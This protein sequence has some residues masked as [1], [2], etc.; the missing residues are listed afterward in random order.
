[1]C[2]KRYGLLVVN[3]VIAL[4]FLQGCQKSPEDDIVTNKNEGVLESI[5]NQT[6]NDSASQNKESIPETY[7]D[8][9]SNDSGDL[10]FNVEADI[11]VAEGDLPV[12]RVA[13]HEI[14]SEE[15]QHWA[16]VLFE[17]KTAYEPTTVLSKSEIEEKILLFRQKAADKDAL[18]SEYGSESEAQAM[19][20]YYNSEAEAYEQLY[21]SAPET[22]ERTESDWTFH[23]Y[24]YYFSN[25]S[26]WD[27]SELEK[28]KQTSELK[29][30]AFDVNG[31]SPLIDALN[32]SAD[33]FKM[34]SLWFWY[35]DEELLSD[36][37]YKEITAEEAKS[38]ADDIIKE[39][40]LENWSI[41]SYI[42][43]SDEAGSF[44]TFNYVP[45]FSSVETIPGLN[46]D[47][48]SDDLYAAN[49]EYSQLEVSVYNG[50]I[51]TVLLT[52][53]LD[54]VEVVNSNVSTLSFDEIYSK[55]KT[56][57]QTQYSLNSFIVGFD[58]IPEYKNAKVDLT[59]TGIQL[60]LV[61]IKEK[62]NDDEYLMVPAWLFTGD[63]HMNDGDGTPTTLC[64][65]NA[66]DGSVINPTLGY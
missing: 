57:M 14:T 36:I 39:L 19:I 3:I 44:Y 30:A 21:E 42:D 20:D 11:Q 33:D 59:V 1:M 65:I 53:P 50:I 63:V 23:S 41:W 61:R 10:T 60:G 37:P 54:V 13:P 64:I 8:S 55:F 31:H 22:V 35:S 6:N 12:V 5:I 18:I 52:S 43:D 4:L 26:T 47:L 25:A 58:D 28:L 17:G 16:E 29:I 15:V 45:S 2:I 62:N 7:I 66:I 51:R 46:I 32:R 38:L 24:D 56:Q 40:N 9:F 34:N 48:Q 27:K 49:Y